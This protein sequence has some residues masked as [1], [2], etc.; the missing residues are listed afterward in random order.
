MYIT[1]VF[2]F[3]RDTTLYIHRTLM[4]SNVD[5]VVGY[6]SITVVYRINNNQFRT[7]ILLNVPI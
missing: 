4:L 2:A 1:L 5:M 3:L 7:M 6:N